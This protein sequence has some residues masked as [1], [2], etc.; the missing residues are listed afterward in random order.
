VLTDETGRYAG[1][2]ATASAYAQPPERDAP[3]S[4]LAANPKISLTPD[5][6]IKAIM[7]AFDETGA[8]ELAVVDTGGEVIGLITEAHVTRRYAEE[9]EKA[10]REL[11]GE[12]A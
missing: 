4:T 9:L 2:V 7:T 1:I 10:R 12:V 8:D 11:T 6:S 5:Q 3:L